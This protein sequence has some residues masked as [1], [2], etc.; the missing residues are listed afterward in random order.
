[1]TLITRNTDYAIRAL[2]ELAGNKGE[3]LSARQIAKRQRV[4]YQFL[5][6]ILRALIKN[7]LIASK[8]GRSGGFRIG[9]NP[10]SITVV[11]VME[12][13]QGDIQLSDCMFRNKPCVNR[14][15]CVLRKRIVKIDKLLKKEFE[16][17]TIGR[18]LKDLKKQ[19][20]RS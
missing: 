10:D 14:S 1:L 5:R 6:R 3:F 8:G 2:I 11:D 15:N 12:I 16:D 7:K 9:K 18:L 17:I 19:K 4:P 20:G 13:F